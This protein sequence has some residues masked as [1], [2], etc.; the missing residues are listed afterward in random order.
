MAPHSGRLIH[1]TVYSKIWFLLPSN[2]DRHTENNGEEDNAIRKG[3][4]IRKC[5][6]FHLKLTLNNK[7]KCM[8]KAAVSFDVD[9]ACFIRDE[10][11]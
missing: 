6:L 7:Q 11:L 4:Y 3:L 9:W 1:Y 5:T 8:Y 10:C 2:Q